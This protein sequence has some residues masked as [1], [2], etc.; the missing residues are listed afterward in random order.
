MTTVDLSWKL[1][2]QK[3]ETIVNKIEGVLAR[4]PID[5]HEPITGS[6]A[7]DALKEISD[8]INKYRYAKG[9]S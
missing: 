3:H 9:V 5:E 8:L 4:F 2:A 1:R 7:V 6:E